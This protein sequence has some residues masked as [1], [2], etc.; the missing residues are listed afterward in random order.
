MFPPDRQHSPGPNTAPFLLLVLVHIALCFGLHLAWDNHQTRLR[1]T[2]E[3]SQRESIR[4]IMAESHPKM[5]LSQT[6]FRLFD[7]LAGVGV[8]AKTIAALHDPQL[9]PLGVTLCFFDERGTPIEPEWGKIPGRY[10]FSRFWEYLTTTQE[11]PAKDKLFQGILGPNHSPDRIRA[12]EGDV[13]TFIGNRTEGLILWKRL[14]KKSGLMLQ[15]PSIPKPFTTASLFLRIASSPTGT[16]LVAPREKRWFADGFDLP[17]RQEVFQR[18]LNQ[19]G[20]T[21]SHQGFL[22]VMEQHPAGFW[23]IRS[24][25]ISQVILNPWWL[26]GVWLVPLLSFALCS[27]FLRGGILERLKLLPQLIAFLGTSF[28]LPAVWLVLL[29]VISYHFQTQKILTTAQEENLTRMINVDMRYVNEREQF[30]REFSRLAPLPAIRDTDKAAI[31]HL[32]RPRRDPRNIEVLQTHA[33]NGSLLFTNTTNKMYQQWIGMLAKKILRGKATSNLPDPESTVERLIQNIINS[34]RLSLGW[35]LDHPNRPHSFQVGHLAFTFCWC[36]LPTS[37]AQQAAFAC[38]SRINRYLQ[39]NFFR[40]TLPRNTW[41]FNSESHEWFPSPPADRRLHSLALQAALSQ[42]PVHF[43]GPED[44]AFML[45]AYPSLQIPGFALVTSSSLAAALAQARR[46]KAIPVII[47]LLMALL[48]TSLAFRVHRSFLVPIRELSHGIEA[49][50][51]G[52]FHHRLPELGRDELGRLGDEMNHLC[53]EMAEIGKARQVQQSHLPTALRRIG[54]YRIAIHTTTASELGG[55]YCDLIDTPDGGTFFILGD[56]TGHGIG[57]SLIATMMKTVCSS[58]FQESSSLE[59]VIKK[60]NKVLFQAVKRKKHMTAVLGILD[61]ARNMVEFCCA[62]H[63]YP[64]LRGAD[65]QTRFLEKPQPPLGFRPNYRWTTQQIALAPGD[66]LVLYTDGI[67]EATNLAGESYGFGQLK[68]LVSRLGSLPPDQII[69]GLLTD[70]REF[71][72]VSGT[73]DDVTFCVIQRGANAPTES[74]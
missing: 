13:H 15:V 47:L 69:S 20:G 23:L 57:A 17:S 5:F 32:L 56:V 67:V 71:T 58:T 3:Q 26:A 10:V 21:F 19:P 30:A 35:M 53:T 46:E 51:Q 33:K 62:G 52:K 70:L 74:P 60:M 48:G 37:D 25:P 65:G 49:M 8:S 27:G 11:T 14:G 43:S 4:T 61:P 55:D 66:S 39:A 2:W 54:E 16:T 34:P 41:A 45:S 12:G 68:I 64:L 40:K 9:R 59:N 73:E 6:F 24:A 1:K 18:G 28:L 31:A 38:M 7:H 36:T 50:V 22:H 72:G 42:K 29:N 63:P 44:S